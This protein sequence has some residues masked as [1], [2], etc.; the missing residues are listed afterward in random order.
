MDKKMHIRLITLSDLWDIF[1]H[2]WW[3]ILIGAV[4]AVAILFTVFTLTFV[5]EYES[6]ATLYILKQNDSQSGS[7]NNSSEDFSLALKV[8]NDCNHLLKGHSVLDKVI[9]NLDLDMTYDQLYKAITVTNPSDTR[10]LEVKVESESPELSKRIVD[11]I[12]TVGTDKIE[13]AMGFQQVNLYELGII[14][15]EPCNKLGLAAYILVGIGVAIAIYTVFLVRFILDDNIRTDEEIERHFHLSILGDIPDSTE[16]EKKKGKY[17]RYYKGNKYGSYGYGY[18]Y[19]Y[20]HN[21]YDTAES[22]DA[23]PADATAEAGA[24]PVT[25]AAPATTETE[26]K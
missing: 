19:G 9:E 25:D 6:V 8:V 11:E 12:C 16:S 13:E 20:G 22:T 23:A 21:P 4:L 1:L 10:I 7:N 24:E 17:Y 15:N 5:P 3:I 26:A 14:N 18:G 2:R